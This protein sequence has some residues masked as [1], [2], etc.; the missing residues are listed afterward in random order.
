MNK[1]LLLTLAVMFSVTVFSDGH[2]SAEKTVLKNV[3]AYWEARNTRDWD[4]V[5][6]LT[7]S[8]GMLGTNS[9]GS[10]H[11]PLNNQTAED[12][13]NQTPAVAG[14]VGVYAFEAHYCPEE[15]KEFSVKHKLI[16]Y[17]GNLLNLRKRSLT[18]KQ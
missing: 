17:L 15:L 5:V 14:L 10:F 8:S 9:D 2:S 7:S 16:G 13:E 18:I 12:W 11:K 1:N 4:T 3:E 6:A